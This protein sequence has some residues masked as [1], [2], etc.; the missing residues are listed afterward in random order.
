MLDLPSEIRCQRDGCGNVIDATPGRV[1]Q[2]EW[3]FGKYGAPSFVCDRCAAAIRASV[4]AAIAKVPK[5][6]VGGVES[7]DMNDALKALYPIRTR[8]N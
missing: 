2:W 7:Y 1:E 4:D 5:T 6:T 3:E 8:T